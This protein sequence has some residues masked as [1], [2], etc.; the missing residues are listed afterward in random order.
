M[1][2]LHYL[3]FRQSVRYARRYPNDPLSNPPFKRELD[4]WRSYVGRFGITGRM[5][6]RCPDTCAL[7]PAAIHTDLAC[8]FGHS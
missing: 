7:V 1:G 5:Q 6:V 2:I 3:A 4:E 8:S